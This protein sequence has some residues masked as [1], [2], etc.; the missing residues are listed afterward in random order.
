MLQVPL[1]SAWQGASDNCCALPP[2]QVTLVIPWLAAPDQAI[3]YNKITFDTPAQQEAYVRSW[4]R[5]RTGLPCNFKVAFYPGRYAAEKCS[6]LPV[7]DPTTYIPDNEVGVLVYFRCSLAM[8]VPE[9]LADHACP[10]TGRRGDPGGA[11]APELVPPRAPLDRQ[12]RARGGHHPH[13]LPGLRAARGR[14]R[15]QG[16]RAQR[17]QPGHL[18]HALPQGAPLLFPFWLACSGLLVTGA[19][20]SPAACARQVVK[21]S[22]AVQQL[23]R[24]VTEFV[25]GVPESF[26]AVG[27]AKARPPAEGQRRFSKGAYFIGK[28]CSGMIDLRHPAKAWGQR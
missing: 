21:L 14:R 10:A 15:P 3:V 18:P 4:A 26:L 11:R 1:A 27:E 16:A 20:A 8:H 12:V 5:Q 23:P 6:I 7:G 2:H 28:V 22:D 24:S 19:Q 25:H 13:Q 9:H 17:G